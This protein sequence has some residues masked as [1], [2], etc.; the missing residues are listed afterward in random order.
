MSTLVHCGTRYRPVG[1]EYTLLDVDTHQYW[2]V[3]NEELAQALCAGLVAIED[4]WYA[5]A[6]QGDG[7]DMRH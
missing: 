7:P 3:D 2:R 1:P 4:V 6:G 5:K